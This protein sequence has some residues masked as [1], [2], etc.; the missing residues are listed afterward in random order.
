MRMKCMLALIC[1]SGSS[2][3]AVENW[4]QFR[5]PGGDGIVEGQPLPVNWSESKNVKWKTPIHDRGHSSPVIW[6]N[7]IWLT[8]ATEDGHSLFVIGVDRDSGKILHNKKIFEISEPQ[9]SNRLNSYAS[10]T[11]VVEEG[12]VYVHFGTYGTACLDSKT[13]TVIWQ[14]TDINCDHMMGP[15]SSPFLFED[16]LIFHV[17]GGDTQFIIALN[18]EDGTTAWKTPRSAELTDYDADYRKAYSTALVVEVN[19]HQELI[20]PGAQAVYGYNP[21]TGKELWKVRYKGFSNVARPV[22]YQ[23]TAFINTGY[24]KAQLWAVKL[25]GRG[26]VT[27]THVG[28]KQMKYIGQRPSPLIVDGLIYLV[29]DIGMVSCLDSQNGEA[30]WTERLRGN[31]SASPVL[32]NGRIYFSS[33]EGITTVIKPARSYTHVATNRL[34]EGMMAS[35]AVAGRSLYLRTDSHLYRIE[36]GF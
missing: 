14:R 6:G 12:R 31:F 29:T 36:E 4:P 26:D 10:P 7:R 30:V 28:W 13:G 2:V 22:V 21:H 8:T 19:G 34:D 20:S 32:A 23:G 9:F 24:N 5:G 3:W 11:P 27:K 16:K 15:G 33:Q 18:K 25:G 35:L 17:D 1:L